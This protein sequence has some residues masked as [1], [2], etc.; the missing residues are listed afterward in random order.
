MCVCACARF[1]AELIPKESRD[2]NENGHSALKSQ[3]GTLPDTGIFGPYIEELRSTDSTIK[4]ASTMN[5]H[6]PQNPTSHGL[7]HVIDP[8]PQLLITGAGTCAQ[9]P[10]VSKTM[11]LKSYIFK[12]YKHKPSTLET[13]TLYINP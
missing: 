10:E 11:S 1:F 5:H 8:L 12:A 6:E 4:L 9:Q 7:V 13:P 3:H 2:R